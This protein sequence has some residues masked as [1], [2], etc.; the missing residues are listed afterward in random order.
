M[1]SVLCWT[2]SSI[3]P[4][5]SRSWKRVSSNEERVGL[6]VDLISDFGALLSEFEEIGVTWLR[7]YW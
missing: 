5:I 7:A 1:L 3:N 2:V 4:L 6:T